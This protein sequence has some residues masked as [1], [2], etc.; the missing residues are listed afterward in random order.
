MVNLSAATGLTPQQIEERLKALHG[1]MKTQVDESERTRQ[2]ALE[3]QSLLE[4]EGQETAPANVE[5]GATPE[6]PPLPSL[7]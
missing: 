2:E 7:R 4:E 5:E 6:S 3:E 1:A